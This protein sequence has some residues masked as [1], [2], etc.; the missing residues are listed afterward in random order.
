MSQQNRRR[1]GGRI[2]PSQRDANFGG[3]ILGSTIPIDEQYA[4]DVHET[5]QFSLDI[6]TKRGHRNRIKH[7]YEFFLEVMPE[8]AAVGVRDL[9]EAELNDPT[10][11]F[12]KN[13]KDLIYDGFN[14]DFFKAFISKKRVI[15]Q[16][17]CAPFHK[18]ST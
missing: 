18:T 5:E 4:R 14:T 10:K 17:L 6:A 16:K 1:N 8:Y 15:W 12:W 13:T 9:T 11:F 7:V 3:E 2:H